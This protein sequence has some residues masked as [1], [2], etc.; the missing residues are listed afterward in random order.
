ML[1]ED[2]NINDPSQLVRFLSVSGL[3]SSPF[4]EQAQTKN[5]PPPAGTTT[6]DD[7][8]ARLEYIRDRLKQQFPENCTFPP[9][10]RLD[11]KTRNSGT[12]IDFI[13][14]VP[15]CVVEKSFREF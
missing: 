15:L 10:Y 7:L 14:P 11:V 5:P 6:I 4:T 13:A 9:G 3:V 2:E 1:A 12:G 8:S